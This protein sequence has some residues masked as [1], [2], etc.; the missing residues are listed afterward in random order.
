[1]LNVEVQLSWAGPLELWCL[2]WDWVASW[3]FVCTPDLG[4]LKLIDLDNELFIWSRCI[5]S[6]CPTVTLCYLC[7]FLITQTWTVFWRGAH[8]RGVVFV[9]RNYDFKR[10]KLI[11]DW[12]IFKLR[13]LLKSWPT[14]PTSNRKLL[15]YNH[16]NKAAAGQTRR[17]SDQ[18]PITENASVTQSQCVSLLCCKCTA[19]SQQKT[20]SSAVLCLVKWFQS[21][22]SDMLRRYCCNRTQNWNSVHEWSWW[23]IRGGAGEPFT[24]KV[25][26]KFF[27]TAF[28][29]LWR[30]K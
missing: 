29:H 19:W 27:G 20:S 22:Q 1:M 8:N 23:L 10:K 25:T 26:L 30:V 7:Y 13:V 6:S 24:L 5:K 21:N 14:F 9:P 18:S 28:R 15:V 2:S 17:T 11:I 16:K 12:L 3:E 4:D